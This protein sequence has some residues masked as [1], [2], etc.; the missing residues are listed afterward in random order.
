MKEKK[1][2]PTNPN[3]RT[4][5]TG[6]AAKQGQHG[7]QGQGQK[8][9]LGGSNQT[10]GA[11]YGDKNKQQNIGGGAQKPQQPGQKK[12]PNDDKSGKNW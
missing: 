10:A 4:G 1:M 2:K 6:D 12:N 5:S 8:P 3:D 7:Q 9:N 11:N